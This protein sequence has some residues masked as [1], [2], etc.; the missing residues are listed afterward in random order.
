HTENVTVYDS[1]IKGEY[2][3]WYSKNLRLVRCT[4]EGTQPLC[5]CE[6]LVLEDCTMKNC[7]LAFEYCTVD[8]TV[9]G[10]IDS[11][12]NPIHGTIIADS[13][14]EIIRDENQKPESDCVIV[15]GND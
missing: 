5:Y 11:V 15:C 8:A 10:H 1:V 7:D 3:A 14:G 6:G 9:R 4:I 13:I 12:K 2:L